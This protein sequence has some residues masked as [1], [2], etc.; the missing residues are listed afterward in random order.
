MD[1]GDKKVAKTDPCP[2]L[3]YRNIQLKCLRRKEV[4]MEAIIDIL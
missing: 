2:A 3:P 1:M 4:E